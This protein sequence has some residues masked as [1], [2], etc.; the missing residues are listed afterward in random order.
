MRRREFVVGIGAAA[1]MWPSAAQ[2]QQQGP[3][4]V[5]G[6]LNSASRVPF[7]HLAAAFRKDLREEGFIEG[8]TVVIEERW[9][10]GRYDRLPALAE[11]LAQRRNLVVAATG[12]AMSGV[13]AKSAVGRVPIVFVMGGDPV[14]FGLVASLSRPGGNITGITQLT[15]ELAAKR[16]GLLHELVPDMKRVAVLL[17]PDFSDASPQ[18][19]EV[20]TA[21]A[22]AGFEPVI[23]RA[24]TEA[25]FAPAFDIIAR[26]RT[27]A[28]LIGADPF[29]NSRR[30]QLVALV[31][32]QRIPTIYEFREFTEAG[33]LMSYGTDLADAYRLVGVYVGRVL[34]GAHPSDLPVI[35]ASKFEFIINLRT[36]RALD[37]TIPPAI[38]ARADEV[39][40]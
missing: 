15:I 1:V 33:G 38:L 39:I 25:E 4:P 28:L 13:A 30:D 18:L 31:A 29:F 40:E 32:R 36:A 9:A 12:G 7:A 2:P 26:E 21:S 3:T 5:V 19:R 34:K 20:E 22:Q 14:K 10:D 16:L 24:R 23:V 11:D 27:D 8:E 17:N 35:Q 37:L 6:F